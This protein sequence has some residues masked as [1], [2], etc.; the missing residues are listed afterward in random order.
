MSETAKA[1]TFFSTFAYSK[2]HLINIKA[3]WKLAFVWIGAV[4][5]FFIIW[6]MAAKLIRRASEKREAEKQ[7]ETTEHDEESAPQS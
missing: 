2:R 3:M 5:L 6:A 1:M 4:T 7:K